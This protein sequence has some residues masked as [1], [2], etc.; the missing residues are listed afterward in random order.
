M[1]GFF[2]SASTCFRAVSGSWVK[3]GTCRAGRIQF[4]SP[5]R[6]AH[7]ALKIEPNI[8]F[9]HSRRLLF[10]FAPLRGKQLLRLHLRKKKILK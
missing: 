9:W 5:G 1:A 2:S 3:P 7:T 8:I 6:R 4:L 10:D